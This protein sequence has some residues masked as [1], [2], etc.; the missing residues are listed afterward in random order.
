MI[1]LRAASSESGGGD[2]VKTSPWLPLAH[3]MVVVLLRN[4]R[5]GVRKKEI[6]RKP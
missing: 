6:G 5:R 3:S 2:K 1:V 4:N